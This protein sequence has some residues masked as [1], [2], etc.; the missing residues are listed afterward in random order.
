MISELIKRLEKKKYSS[1]DFYC[2]SK[3][4]RRYIH[5]GKRDRPQDCYYEIKNQ[6]YEAV[7]DRIAKELYVYKDRIKYNHYIEMSI[8]DGREK[9]KIYDYIIVFRR[10]NFVVKYFGEKSELWFKRLNDEIKRKYNL[11]VLPWEKIK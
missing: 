3:F 10:N 4:D 6:S 11:L 9:P 2:L 8:Y 1:D 7:V 5:V